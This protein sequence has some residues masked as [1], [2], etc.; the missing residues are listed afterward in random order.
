MPPVMTNQGDDLSD[1][2]LSKL[3]FDLSSLRERTGTF[4]RSYQYDLMILKSAG[5]VSESEM[6]CLTP[7]L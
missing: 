5:H 3:N 1:V 7:L 4:L 2:M 6:T